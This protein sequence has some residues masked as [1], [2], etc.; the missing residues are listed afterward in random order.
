MCTPSAVHSVSRLRVTPFDSE[1]TYKGPEPQ[2]DA[3][4]SAKAMLIFFSV[5][6][7]AIGRSV[8]SVGFQQLII[9]R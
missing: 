1:P 8:T 9:L 3:L 7:A 4:L 5:S 2:Q 6:F